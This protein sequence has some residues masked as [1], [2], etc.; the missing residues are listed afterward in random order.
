MKSDLV[1]A[2]EDTHSVLILKFNVIFAKEIIHLFIET[3]CN[4]AAIQYQVEALWA[5]TRGI[6]VNSDFT[7]TLLE[8]EV[9][10]FGKWALT[11]K[12]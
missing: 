5:E 6:Q 7:R 4:A 11:C 9:V 8:N 3:A 12:T 10:R 2:V 1:A